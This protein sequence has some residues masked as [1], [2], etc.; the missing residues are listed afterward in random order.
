M[1]INLPQDPAVPKD[2]SSYPRETNLT[3]FIAALFLKARNWK[4]PTCLS[5]EEWIEKMYIYTIKCYSAVK[6]TTS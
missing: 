6:N 1:E 5:T 2:V 3:I 4:Q